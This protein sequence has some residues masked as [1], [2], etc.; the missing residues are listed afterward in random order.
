M[1]YEPYRPRRRPSCLGRLFRLSLILLVLWAVFT[2]ITNLPAGIKLPFF[3]G[4]LSLND[5]LPS[6]YTNILLLGEDN[7]DGRGRTDT[8]MVAT[9]GGGEIKL[10]SIMRDTLVDLGDY[11]RQKINAAYRLGGET[12]AMRV[13]N[14]AF[15][16][17]ITRYAV[18]DFEGFSHLIDSVGG[19]QVNVTKAEMQQINQGVKK[20]WKRLGDGTGN[21]RYLERYGADVLLTGPQ[22]LAYSRIRKIDSDY[23]RTS[24][25][26]AVIEALVQKLRENRSPIV[27]AKLAQT[28]LSNVKTNVNVLEIGILG[29]RALMDGQR[30][31]Q[32]RLPADGTFKSGVDGGAWV[33]KPD[34]DKNRKLLHEFLYD[35]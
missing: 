25:Q 24:R 18:I 3:D 12:L 2:L 16:L 34:F 14:Q 21:I 7:E 13:V 19:V 27:L 15:G 23:M 29:V 10:T 32:L 22:A 26:R 8:I 31:R 6:G 1:Y 33:I 30:V 9:I 35:D 5:L 20:T 11:G 17:D 28:A 4:D